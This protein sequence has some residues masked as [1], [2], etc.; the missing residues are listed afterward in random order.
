MSGTRRTFTREF[1][2]AAVKLVTVKGRWLAKLLMS[3][4][5]KKFG[6]CEGGMSAKIRC[7]KER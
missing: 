1:K 2:V 4:S 3:P 5:V 6:C 7:Q